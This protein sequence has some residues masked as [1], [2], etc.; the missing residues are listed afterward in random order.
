MGGLGKGEEML[1]T[2]FKQRNIDSIVN[3]GIDRVEPDA[4]I[5]TDGRSLP[6]QVTPS[7]SLR[8]SAS[9]RSATRRGCATWRGFVPVDD[10]YQH[11]DFPE[12]YS[13]GVAVAVAPPTPTEVPTGVPK[14]GYMSEVMGH[15]ACPQHR[16][17]RSPAKPAQEKRFGDINGAV[18]LGCRGR[19]GRD[20]G[21]PTRSS[22]AT[23]DP[24]CSFRARGRTGESSPSRSTPVE[25]APRSGLTCR[26]RAMRCLPADGAPAGSPESAQ[27]TGMSRTDRRKA[28]DVRLGSCDRQR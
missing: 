13:A 21:S 18:H 17:P 24:S 27:S 7:S 14:T 2:F 3:T 22:K 5:L 4:V 10:R 25:D 9:T 26:R 19:F 6:F 11:V 1:K 12:I 20:H 23:Q 16:G 15:L 8:S 28:A